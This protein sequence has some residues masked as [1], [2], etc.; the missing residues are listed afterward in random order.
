MEG[1]LLSL[2]YSWVTLVDK[3]FRCEKVHIQVDRNV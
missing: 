2:D 1:P 3:S